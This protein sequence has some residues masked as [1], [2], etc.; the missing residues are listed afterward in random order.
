[1]SE[2]KTETILFSREGKTIV[3]DLYVPADAH[4]PLPA[5]ILSHGYGGDGR[6]LEC[7]ARIFA[8]NGFFACSFDFCGGGNAS[9]SD[10]TPLEMSVLTEAAD[11]SAVLDGVRAR[12]EVDGTNVFLWGASQ[13]GFVSSYAAAARPEDVRALVALFPAYV[14]QDDSKK[15]APDPSAIPERMDVMGMTLGA[16][17]HRDALSFDIYDRLP[18]FTRPVLLI[19]G[20]ADTLVP[21]S[22]SERAEKTFPDARLLRIPGAGHG[23]W[24]EDWKTASDAALRFMKENLG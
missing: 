10:G 6:G 3:G 17:Y 2:I 20:T 4:V 15:R 8:E 19:H 13:G 1:M 12:P 9:R 7:D 23:F 21:I 16:I 22:Y 5:V 11:L 14:L 24:G 18:A